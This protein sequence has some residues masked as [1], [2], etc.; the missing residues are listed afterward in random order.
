MNVISFTI[1]FIYRSQ[2]PYQI[3]GLIQNL[4]SEFKKISLANPNISTLFTQNLYFEFAEILSQILAG[5]LE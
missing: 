2:D 1:L 5:P 4:L 3:D